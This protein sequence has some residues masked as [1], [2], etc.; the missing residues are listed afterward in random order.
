MRYSVPEK[1]M[2]MLWEEDDF[3]NTACKQGGISVNRFPK[4]DQWA[5]EEGYHLSFC[6]AGYGPNDILIEV[7]SN[8]LTLSSNGISESPPEQ[9]V[10]LENDDAM[11]EYS[12]KAKPVIQKG[13]I[14]RGIARR[15]FKVSYAVSEVFDCY[16]AQASI[17]HGLLDIVIPPREVV[18]SKVVDIMEKR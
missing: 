6:L 9:P 2:R 4:S 3:F 16:K 8:T 1:L 7:T 10:I 15:S 12:K 11:S 5:D 14:S 17:E 13:I 18:E